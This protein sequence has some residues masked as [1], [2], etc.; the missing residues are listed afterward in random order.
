M[1][2]QAL[3]LSG[4]SSGAFTVW[5]I[6]PGVTRIGRSP[7]NS[8]HIPD[9]TVSKE[10]AELTW[11]AWRCTITDLG[12]RNGTRVNGEEV[13]ASMDVYAGDV[14][15][16]GDVSLLVTDEVPDRRVRYSESTTLGLSH[17]PGGTKPPVSSGDPEFETLLHESFEAK[18]PVVPGHPDLDR[19]ADPLSLVME[20]GKMLVLPRPLHETCDAI[21]EFVARGIPASRHVLLL[22]DAEDS[23]PVTLA[24]KSSPE[25]K[26]VPL[27]LS[28]AITRMVLDEGRSV[29]TADA[30]KDPR[31]GDRRSI[32]EQSVHSAMAVPL[33]DDDRVLG[34]LYVDS[35]EPGR[36]FEEKRLKLLTLLA[37]MAAVKISNARLLKAEEGRLRIN[38]E[39]A[40][41]ARIQRGLLPRD[42][43][44]VPGWEIDAY[45]E[46]CYEVGGDLFDYRLAAG[47]LDVMIGDVSGKG[48]GAA[49][50]MS[51]FLASARVLETVCSSPLELAVRLNDVMFETTAP[52]DFITGVIGRLD[53]ASGFLTLVNAGHPDVYIIGPR[54]IT[55][56]RSS[57]PGFA[58]RSGAQFVEE[59]MHMQSGETFV[60][61]TDG[62]SEARREGQFFGEERV[63]DV[64]S[65]HQNDPIIDIRN[66]LLEELESFLDGAHRTDDVSLLLLRRL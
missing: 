6:E 26:H 51:S 49:L 1:S 36:V 52:Q 44:D 39:L 41:A 55:H 21:L 54:G 33:R 11:Y 16:V 53:P 12:S 65:R 66:A 5:K 34:L 63:R 27:A 30:P 29:L 42:A 62:V 4:I 2:P 56:V 7:L 43:P 35:Q 47:Q 9:P 18:A 3:Y 15:E 13:Y 23:E 20:A 31:F 50:V 37:N 32:F 45:L 17:P 40:A 60:A 14:L 64:L 19:S 28:R 10:H 58:M 61:F 22:R 46:P 25:V 57:G 38:Q 24:S 48:M 59:E 8:V